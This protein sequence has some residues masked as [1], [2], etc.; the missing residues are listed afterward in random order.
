MSTIQKPNN[1]VRQ[2]YIKIVVL[3][4]VYGNYLTF[5]PNGEIHKDCKKPK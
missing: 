4:N 5:F 1:G 3:M 2:L